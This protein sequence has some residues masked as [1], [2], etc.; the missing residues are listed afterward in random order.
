MK[1][2]RL[3][4]RSGGIAM[5][6]RLLGVAAVC[7]L[8]LSSAAMGDPLTYTVT[9]LGPGFALDI[10]N[11]GQVVLNDSF[12][13]NNGVTTYLGPNSRAFGINNAGQVVGETNL[14]GGTTVATV[15]NGTTPTYLVNPSG[16]SQQ[17]WPSH[18]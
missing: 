5:K 12:I 1:A 4:I 6:T 13:W 3:P 15:W 17:F 7:L 18:Q 2:E 9:D 14:V 11:A 8:G 16:N 10:N